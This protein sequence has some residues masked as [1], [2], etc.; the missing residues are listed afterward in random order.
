MRPRLHQF[1]LA[2]FVGLLFVLGWGASLTLARVAGPQ[3]DGLPERVS[4]NTTLSLPQATVASGE[5][6]T[7]SLTVSGLTNLLYSADIVVTYDP[8]VATAVQVNRGS[9]LDAWSMATNLQ[10]SG[11]VTVALAGAQPVNADGEL[12]AITFT[13]VG[14]EGASSP[15]LLDTGSLNEGVIPA[16][17][18]NGSLTIVRPTTTPTPESHPATCYDFLP[19][20]GVGI[21]DIRAVAVRWRLTAANPDPDQNP[22]TPNYEIQYD[23]APDTP[24]GII[25]VLDVITVQSHYGETCS[26]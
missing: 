23:V 18:Q 25:N 5:Q 11:V 10:T 12:L 22:N 2:S 4:Q 15:L 16:T 1:L 7:L 21:E 6:V 20:E 13:A 19:P 24:D 17:L 26:P 8:A 9:L 3:Q 14:A